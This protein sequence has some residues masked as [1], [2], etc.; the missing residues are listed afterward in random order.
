MGTLDKAIL[1]LQ[2]D[3]NELQKDSEITR[4]EVVALVTRMDDRFLKIMSYLK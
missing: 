4:E 3:T 1:E 2:K